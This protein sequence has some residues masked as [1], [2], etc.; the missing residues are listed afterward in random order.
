LVCKHNIFPASCAYRK[1]TVGD[2]LSATINVLSVSGGEDGEVPIGKTSSS[3][4]VKLA[5]KSEFLGGARLSGITAV[6]SASLDAAFSSGGTKLVSTAM[7]E[8]YPGSTTIGDP[9][10]TYIAPTTEINNLFAKGYSREVIAEKL[11]ITDKKF[12][13]GDLIRVDIDASELKTLN[14]RPATGHEVGANSQHV[15]GGQ[16]IGKVT[17]GVVNGIPINGQGISI[18][19]VKSN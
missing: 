8:K 14:L 12:L 5:P 11:G 15:T 3:L 10:E 2:Y 4:S 19:K 1:A 18:N 13:N 16:T 7:L 17:E 6:E 9:L